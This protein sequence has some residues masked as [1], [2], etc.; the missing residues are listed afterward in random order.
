MREV[1][2][3][4]QS[5]TPYSMSKAINVEKLDKEHADEFEKRT[6]RERCNY[7]EKGECFIPPMAF[8]KALVSVAKLL[9]EKIK[10]KGNQEW[11]KHFTGG[12]L[13]MEGPGLGVT[14]DDCEGEWVFVPSDGMSGGGKRVWKCFPV[15]REWSAKVVFTIINDTITKD[16]FERY[17]REAGSLIGLGRF[18][19]E[20]MGFYGRFA[21]TKFDWR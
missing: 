17:V 10:G 15:V 21:V 9:K 11:T 5:I 2:V 4:M 13:V 18:R 1:I 3:S 12:V 19:P 7:N 6:W 14:K 16:V 20:R 8:A